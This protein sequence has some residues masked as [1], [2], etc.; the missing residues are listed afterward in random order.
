LKR[1]RWARWRRRAGGGSE[2]ERIFEPFYRTDRSRARATGGV[3]PGL[4]LSRRIVEAHGGTI[5]AE[6]KLEHGSCF[7]I[8]LPAVA[9]T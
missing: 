8:T 7:T 9:Q 5:R 6:S 2:L 1:R 3:G 4:A